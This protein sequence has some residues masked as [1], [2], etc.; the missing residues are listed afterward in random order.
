MDAVV[1]V[2]V[3]AKVGEDVISAR[4][5]IGTVAE[6]I[7]AYS[8]PAPFSRKRRREI[9]QIHMI[10]RAPSSQKLISTGYLRL[11]LPLHQRAFTF[12]VVNL[13]PTIPMLMSCIMLH[14]PL[15]CL[16]LFLRTRPRMTVTTHFSKLD[17]MILLLMPNPL[18]LCVLWHKCTLTMVLKQ[19]VT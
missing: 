5:T 9:I 4:N 17:E 10:M 2:E 14:L 11:D 3:V 13:N 7:M 18:I 16:T 6:I 15:R 19:L 8:V 12:R 1:T